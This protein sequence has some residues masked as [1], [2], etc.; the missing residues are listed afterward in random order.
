MDII[1][2]IRILRK[3]LHLNASS[4]YRKS[5]LFFLQ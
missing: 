3:N 4:V 5:I 2:T 1:P